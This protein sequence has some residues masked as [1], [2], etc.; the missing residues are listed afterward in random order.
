MAATSSARRLKVRGEYKGRRVRSLTL[1][2]QAAQVLETEHKHSFVGV[3]GDLYTI[4]ECK[5]DIADIGEDKGC[6]IVYPRVNSRCAG[7]FTYTEQEQL[8]HIRA[9]LE[10]LNDVIQLSSATCPFVVA[11]GVVSTAL[12]GSPDD[13][14]L[15]LGNQDIDLFLV[16]ISE[17]AAVHELN[18]FCDKLL[19]KHKRM[20]LYRNLR[21]I[22]AIVPYGD[23]AVTIQVI[24][25]RYNTI[26]EILH[27]FDLG[28]SAVAFHGDKFL[29]S[30]KG[31]FAFETGLNILDL[32]RRRNTYERRINKYGARGFGLV[33]PGF[34][35]DKVKSYLRTGPHYTYTTESKFVDLCIS[36]SKIYEICVEVY[37]GMKYIPHV[38]YQY[39]SEVSELLE[40]KPT[41]TQCKQYAAQDL[42]QRVLQR[43]SYINRICARLPILRKIFED[44][45]PT[46]CPAVE[47]G[48]GFDDSRRRLTIKMPSTDIRLVRTTNVDVER[49]YRLEYVP[50]YTLPKLKQK[51]ITY[52]ISD[53]VK[54][55]VRES[56]NDIILWMARSG[57]KD[58]TRLI[59]EY[60]QDPFNNPG[61]NDDNYDMS[62][63]IDYNPRSVILSNVY[64]V[65][66]PIPSVNAMC[67]FAV[68]DTELGDIKVDVTRVNSMFT[69][70]EKYVQTKVE[71][72]RFDTLAKAFGWDAGQKLCEQKLLSAAT[73][74]AIARQFVAEFLAKYDHHAIPFKFMELTDSTCLAGGGP[75]KMA[76][77]TEKEWY[78]P[79]ARDQ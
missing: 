27:G 29:F 52:A 3:T 41:D 17:E 56:F 67:A 43:T 1:L 51:Q 16:G 68:F 11:G 14:G 10:P 20:E 6:K 64:Q 75:L 33:V 35:L 77:M 40:L 45:R 30:S 23:I 79:F 13:L 59:Y 7:I 25:R 8:E 4:N 46:S 47:I 78:G 71:T 44:A 58:V 69:G 42:Y 2:E 54:I 5:V 32:T 60:L 55:P 57:V 24:L 21:C 73:S 50:P 12:C 9:I 39:Q 38:I 31:R 15:V 72:H 36:N 63:C 37:N 19:K 66:S 28:S 76:L 74:A 18:S 22:T 62:L 26:S 49:K 53:K 61:E 70:I 34:S 65:L 48:T